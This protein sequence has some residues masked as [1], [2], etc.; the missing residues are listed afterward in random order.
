VSLLNLSR[1][2]PPSLITV[3]WFVLYTALPINAAYYLW[4][5]RALRSTTPSQLSARWR[6]YVLIQGLITGAY[7]V[8]LLIAPDLCSAFWPWKID[9]F[10]G[11]MYSAVFLTLAVG[12]LI[13]WRSG[14][15]I[16]VLTLGAIQI[17]LGSLAILGLAIVDLS[18]H[19]VAWIAAGTLAWNGA[20]LVILLTGISMI[21]TATTNS[22]VAGEGVRA[23]LDRNRSRS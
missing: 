14:S 19:T 15:G 20:F 17:A 22:T 12:S 8:G 10:H 21:R 16:G 4:T 9:D 6:G 23:L 5:S 2:E 11:Q 13:V 1:L 18:V 3:A 7:G